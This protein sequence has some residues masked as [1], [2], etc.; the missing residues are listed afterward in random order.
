MSRRTKFEIEEDMKEIKYTLF[1]E[2]YDKGDEVMY[3]DLQLKIAH[4]DGDCIIF[5]AFGNKGGLI[6]W[7][8]L[9]LSKMKNISRP[10]RRRLDVWQD[11]KKTKT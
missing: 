1:R 8:D 2:E 5:E 11:M 3:G 4:F 6:R 9:D 10:T 7:V